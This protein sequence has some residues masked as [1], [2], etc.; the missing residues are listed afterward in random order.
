MCNEKVE[1]EK[2]FRGFAYKFLVYQSSSGL[3]R[4]LIKDERKSKW[5]T[6]NDQYDSKEGAIKDLESLVSLIAPDI[7]DAEKIYTSEY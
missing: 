7:R 3:W 6:F 2:V 1:L 4:S 5:R